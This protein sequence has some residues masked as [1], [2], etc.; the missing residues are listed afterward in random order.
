MNLSA[1]NPPLTPPGRGTGQSVPLP[2]WEGFG[3]RFMI[4]MHARK[5]K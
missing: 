2:S 3:G 5:R 1:T 4:A